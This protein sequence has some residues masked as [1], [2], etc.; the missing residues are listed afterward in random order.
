MSYA[1]PETRAAYYRQYYARNKERMRRRARER[2]ARKR[3]PRWWCYWLLDTLEFPP[4]PEYVVV[5]PTPIR[6]PTLR[7]LK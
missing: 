4:E 6:R 2:T 7:L 5:I 1:D 3:S